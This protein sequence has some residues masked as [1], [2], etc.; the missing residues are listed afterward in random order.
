MKVS[1][2]RVLDG[3]AK[4]IDEFILPG[5]NDWQELAARI[6]IGRVFNNKDALR[7][8][9]VNNGYIRSFALID[10]EGNIDID[11]LAADIKRE[12]ER[13]GKLEVDLK[14][15]GKLRFSPTDVNTL[16]RMITQEA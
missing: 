12:I 13:K 11:Q 6:A 14:L 5:M 4:Y 10:D 1:F 15:F 16:K 7:A 8:Y 3:T 9:V 2:N